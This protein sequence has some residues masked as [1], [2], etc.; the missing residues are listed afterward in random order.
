MKIDKNKKKQNF[1]LKKKSCTNGPGSCL[2][3]I[4]NLGL[5]LEYL[6]KNNSLASMFYFSFSFF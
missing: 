5:H 2:A 3:L 1:F 6:K 4:N